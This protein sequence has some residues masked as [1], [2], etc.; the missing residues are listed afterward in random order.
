MK[1]KEDQVMLLKIN[2]TLFNIKFN[3]PEQWKSKL[4][5]QHSYFKIGIENM[6]IIN[7]KK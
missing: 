6:K 3:S 7:N 4:K 1:E 2:S 5:V